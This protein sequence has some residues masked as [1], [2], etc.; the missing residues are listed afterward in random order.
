MEYTKVCADDPSVV[1]SIVMAC[2]EAA[3]IRDIVTSTLEAAE[4]PGQST[5]NAN[6][7]ETT[8]DLLRF[9]LVSPGFEGPLK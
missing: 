3:S 4:L 1:P 6:R 5:L 2:E 7:V 8:N 9:W